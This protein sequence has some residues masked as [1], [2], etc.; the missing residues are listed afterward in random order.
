MIIIIVIKVI[1]IHKLTNQFKIIDIMVTNYMFII[2]M[3]INLIKFNIIYV[4]VSSYNY[5]Y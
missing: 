4:F 3:F 1:I 2:I 5:Y